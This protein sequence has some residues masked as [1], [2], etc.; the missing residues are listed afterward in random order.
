MGQLLLKA[1]FRRARGEWRAIAAPRKRQ[2]LDCGGGGNR[3]RVRKPSTLRPYV[4]S[5]RFEVGSRTIT[6]NLPPT[7]SRKISPL[8]ARALGA[9]SPHSDGHPEP[10]GRDPGDRALRLFKQPVRAQRRRWLLCRCPRDL[11]VTGP[12]GTRPRASVPPSKPGRP[13]Q[14]PQINRP[15]RP[16]NLCRRFVYQRRPTGDD[17]SGSSPS[18][19]TRA[20][21]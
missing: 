14:P 21:E 18:C 5:P 10:T 11:R 15:T 1:T 8:R 13:L 16:F 7:P 17:F 12:L 19:G 9:A 3:T 20:G 6:D 4:R 2:P